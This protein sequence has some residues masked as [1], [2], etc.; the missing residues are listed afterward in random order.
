MQHDLLLGRDS[1]LRSMTAPT[2]RWL[3]AMEITGVWESSRCRSNDPYSNR[4]FKGIHCRP[5]WI[6]YFW[7]LVEIAFA[8][9]RIVGPCISQE[10]NRA[11]SQMYLLPVMQ[12]LHGVKISSPNSK[13]WSGKGQYAEYTYMAWSGPARNAYPALVKAALAVA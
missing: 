12:Y 13:H 6:L 7:G 8:L 2:V 1:W 9:F 5:S 4:T 10:R 3:P 11:D